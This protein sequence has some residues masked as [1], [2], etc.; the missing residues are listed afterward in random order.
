MM[1]TAILALAL[2][3]TP[4]QATRSNT[5][6]FPVRNGITHLEQPVDIDGVIYSATWPSLAALVAQLERGNPSG[7]KSTLKDLI[8]RG[9]AD[10]GAF[11]LLAQIERHNGD[12]DIAF[13]RIEGAIKTAPRQHLHYFQLALICF[14]LRE[15]ASSGLDRWKWHS[16]TQESYE[17]ALELEPKGVYYRYYVAYS[18]MTTPAAVGGDKEKALK[19]AQEGIHLGLNAFYV[20]RADVYRSLGRLALAFADYDRSLQL[21]FFKTNSFLGALHSALEQKD[22][23]R[24]KSY[25]AFLVAA[26]SDEARA[27]EACGDYL[28]AIGDID[29]AIQS[30]RTALQKNPN[31]TTAAEK[32]SRLKK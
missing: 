30:Y 21:R 22:F 10:D 14:Q 28:S 7:T 23:T 26:K 4:E 8:A 3:M 1:I 31:L 29:K 19:L 25:C 32:L 16:R 27:H 13:N 24:A 6:N 20:I 9:K 11:N 5:Q 18:Y 17:K 15:K 2:T 12:L